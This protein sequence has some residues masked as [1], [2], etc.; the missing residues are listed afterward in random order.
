[1]SQSCDRR[2]PV[3]ERK[4]FARFLLT[5]GFAAMVNIAARWLLNRFMSFEVAVV[6]AFF[7]GLST[8][9]VLGKAF[10]FEDSG[11]TT[12]SE[13][14]RFF[15]VNL[16][17]LALVW[18]ISVML[19]RWIFPAVGFTWHADDFAHVIGVGA[20]AVFAYFGHRSYTFAKAS[21]G[22]GA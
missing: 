6:I 17:S 21:A 18:S 2:D 4:Q 5:S 1:M 3:I 22:D 8:A 11:R 14:T 15:L 9:F 20:P 7:V 13:F 16:A 12:V 19:A 10:V